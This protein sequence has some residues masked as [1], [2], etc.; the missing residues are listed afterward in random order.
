MYQIKPDAGPHWE[1]LVK[2][3]ELEK[4]FT[5]PRPSPFVSR[6]Y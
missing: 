5:P 2:I 1:E 6:F 4:D 3:N